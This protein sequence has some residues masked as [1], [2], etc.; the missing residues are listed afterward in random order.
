[1]KKLPRKFF[2]RPTLEVAEDIVGMV[3]VVGDKKAVIIETEAYFGD[4]AAS[5]GAAGM[6]PRNFPMF[7]VAGHLY[8]YFIYGMYFCLNVTTEKK[9]FP[10]A[11]LIRGIKMIDSG[12]SISGPGK[13]CIALGITKKHNDI[14]LCKSGGFYI[15]DFGIRLKS[16]RTPRIGI[17]KNIHKKWR[18]AA[19]PENHPVPVRLIRT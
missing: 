10:A 15:A 9:G 11:V 3:I 1:M 17:K 2:E 4:D 19:V 13:L 12:E 18:F 14:D 5:H 16:K 8:V 7:G 6:T